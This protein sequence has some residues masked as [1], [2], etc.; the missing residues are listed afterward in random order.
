MGM[1]DNNPFKAPEARV[2]DPGS[3]VGGD[4]ILEGR[5]VPA[6]NGVEWIKRGWELFTQ[7]PGMWI[8]LNLL[9]M[10][11]VM[12]VSMI[13]FL[14]IATNLFMPVFMGGFMIG[15]RA[16]EQGEELQVGH[17]FAGFSDHMGR[18]VLVGLMYLVGVIAIVAVGGIMAAIM[19]PATKAMGAESLAF[20]P[21]IL[22]ALVAMLFMFP[23]VMAIWLAPPLV[24]FHEVP[25][26]EA[27]KASFLGC[28]KNF[29]PFLVYGLVLMVAAVVAM[30]PCFLGLF[31]LG[32]VVFAS[33]YASY[34]DIYIQ[35]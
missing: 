26:F 19:I 1:D 34:Q 21:I 28:L 35:D 15:C 10:V 6:G 25:P 20:I 2:A 22:I 17:L 13:P 30:L 33:M 5:K 3:Y 31:V 29:V 24:V 7:S 12:V 8:A 18:L 27:M 11:M 9:Y 16:L 14:G 32:P 4:F 23:L